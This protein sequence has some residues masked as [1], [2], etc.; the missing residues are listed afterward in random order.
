[1]KTLKDKER[2]IW[3]HVWETLDKKTKKDSNTED[4]EVFLSKDVKEAVLEFKQILIETELIE[5]EDKGAFL[6][7]YEDI[8]GDI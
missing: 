3:S 5:S 4:D 8:F 1:M 2:I 7:L 6:I